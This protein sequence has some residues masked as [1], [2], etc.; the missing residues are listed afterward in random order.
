L[1]PEAAELFP[2]GY[3]PVLQGVL[4][5]LARQLAPESL[6]A[7]LRGVGRRLAGWR[8]V[9]GGGVRERLAAGAELLNDLG[10][11]AEAR[12]IEGVLVVQGWSCPLA[13]VVVDHPE[14]CRVPEAVLAEIIGLPVQERCD[15][16]E[17]P[18]CFF[19]VATAPELQRPEEGQTGPR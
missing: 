4:D 6:E 15:R 16:R 13:S 14:L 11:L 9:P 3:A 2:R 8:P 18:R 1:T 5:E 7:L 17:P 19:A 12:E 10:G